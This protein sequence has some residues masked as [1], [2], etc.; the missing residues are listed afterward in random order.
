MPQQ[1]NLCTADFRPVKNRFGARFLLSILLG[2]L[3]VSG[4]TAAVWV[5]KAQ[6]SN[7]ALLQTSL[8]HDAEIAGLKT[9][10]EKSR[11]A[12]APADGALLAQ[13]EE[14]RATVKRREVLVEAVQEG[15]FKP[16]RGHSDRLLLL[17]RSI[18]QKVWIAD[19]KVD[20]GRFEVA[21]YTLEPD[22]L[23]EWVRKLAVHP[24]MSNLKL[25]NVS[26]EN[27]TTT[28]SK[29][30]AV[31]GV[32]GPLAGVT[33]PVWSYSLVNL[34]PPLPAISKENSAGVKP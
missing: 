7:A 15:V 28:L 34:E 24:L 6:A 27:K 16:G 22:A 25:T 13:L 4:G 12:A 31:A 14:R 19:V 3:T 17:S 23:N 29:S 5:W 21:G 26:V 30:S 9:A 20:Q 32:P 33:G 18:P 8:A 11:A 10:I 1:I 2:A